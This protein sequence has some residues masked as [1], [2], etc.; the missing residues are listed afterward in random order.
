M[1]KG[2]LELSLL[3]LFIYISL[4]HQF[5]MAKHPYHHRG[6]NRDCYKC[7]PGFGVEHPCSHLH[8]TECR[9]CAPDHYSS[10]KSSWRPCYPCSRC[11]TGLY[12]AH[13]CTA[14]RDTVCDSCHTY[15]GPHNENFY[16]RCV[17]PLFDSAGNITESVRNQSS[18]P[19]EN[20][21]VITTGL[22][23]RVQTSVIVASGVAIGVLIAVLAAVCLVGTRCKLCNKADKHHPYMAVSTKE[24]VML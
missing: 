6:Q 5:T 12:V 3:F 10:H 11:G 24:A 17:K 16:E 20:P 2:Y 7:P 21:S 9:A 1:K 13:K 23:R 19:K 14:K 4:T 8:D 22:S 15:R 18:Q